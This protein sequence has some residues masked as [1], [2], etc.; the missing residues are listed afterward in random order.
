MTNT[1]TGQQQQ[2]QQRR[3]CQ[4]RVW[5]QRP[6]TLNLKVFISYSKYI[7]SSKK[8]I[9]MIIRNQQ[10]Q[11]QQL[12]LLLTNSQKNGIL[13]NLSMIFI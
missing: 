3:Q 12:N 5:Q 10:Q 7:C 9:A 11:H 1:N 6:M 13:K 4:Q 8:R 2:Q